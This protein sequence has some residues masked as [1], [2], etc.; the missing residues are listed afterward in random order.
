MV[1]LA[2]IILGGAMIDKDAVKAASKMFSIRRGG[3]TEERSTW[4]HGE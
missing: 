1:P 4:S 2:L 3:D